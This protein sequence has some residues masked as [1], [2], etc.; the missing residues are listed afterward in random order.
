MGEIERLQAL[1]AVKNEFLNQIVN[2]AEAVT[3]AH[4]HNLKIGQA[5]DGLWIA[6]RGLEKVKVMAW[7]A[8]SLEQ[9]SGE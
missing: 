5:D 3:D 1:L 4:A 8:L 2:C 7:R 9:E 6:L